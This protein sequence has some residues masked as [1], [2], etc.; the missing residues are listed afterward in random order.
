M[1]RLARWCAVHRRLVVVL[2]LV[3]A[4]GVTLAGRAA[5]TGYSDT[6]SLAGT[7]STAGSELLRAAAPR[8]AGSAN[9]IVLTTPT[10]TVT[11]A[12]VRTR[13]EAMLARVARQ[14]SRSS[15]SAR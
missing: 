5:G 7:E 1:R 12:G 11:D 8:S 13:V 9:Q 14:P 4:V 6:F 15:A 3:A 10:G 2:W